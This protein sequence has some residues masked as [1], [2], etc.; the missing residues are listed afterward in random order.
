MELT[1]TTP[2][3]LFPAVSLILLAY[4]NRFQAVSK[5]I[6]DLKDVYKQHHFGFHFEQIRTLRKRLV[7]IRN[8]QMLGV[9]ALLGCVITMLLLFVG[10]EFA[11]RITFAVSLVLMIISLILSLKELTLSIHALNLEL[12]DLEKEDIQKLEDDKM[13]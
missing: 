9:A 4:T 11:G 5:R 2:A 3:L 1:V 10:E 7:L 13:F 8:M 6:R 12:S